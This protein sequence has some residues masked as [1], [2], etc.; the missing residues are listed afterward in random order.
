[1]IDLQKKNEKNERFIAWVVALAVLLIIIISFYNLS[2]NVSSLNG[3]P[4]SNQIPKNYTVRS[5][6][7]NRIHFDFICYEDASG[8]PQLLLKSL[9][10]K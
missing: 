3:S 4:C 6:S 5:Q 2:F 10:K 7:K 8:N 9:P 1:M